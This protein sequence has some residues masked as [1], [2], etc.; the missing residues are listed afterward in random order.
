MLT[1]NSEIGFE[2]G[3][4]QA[5]YPPLHSPHEA[6]GVLAEELD[7]FFDQVRLKPELRDPTVMRKEL[8][9][10]A[11]MSIRAIQDFDL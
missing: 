6:Y 10:I 8:I 9:Q 1:I 2:I 5:K 3:R 11:A 7:E 4:S